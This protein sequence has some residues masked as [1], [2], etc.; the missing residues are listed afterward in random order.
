VAESLRFQANAVANSLPERAILHSDTRRKQR[1]SACS[2][3]R[4]RTN[5]L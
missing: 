5:G 1:V 4:G 3:H 2:L